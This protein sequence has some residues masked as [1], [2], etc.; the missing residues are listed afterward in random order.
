L[1]ITAAKDACHEAHDFLLDEAQHFRGVVNMPE[2]DLFGP[3]REP[4]Q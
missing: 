3:G 1:A 2:L 4:L